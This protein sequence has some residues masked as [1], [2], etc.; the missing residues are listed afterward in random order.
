MIKAAIFDL[1]G[2]LGDTVESIAY[3]GN[4]ALADWDIHRFPLRVTNIMRVTVWMS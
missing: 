4:R 2:T 1:D 3:S